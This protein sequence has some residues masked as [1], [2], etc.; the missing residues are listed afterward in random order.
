[1]RVLADTH[2]VLW[3]FT[4]S[5]R[6]TERATSLLEAETTDV[7]LS[8]VVVWEIA[9]KRAIGKLDA[10]TRYRE[11]FLGAGAEALPIEHHHAE[12]A[13]ALPPH[14]RDPFD[15]ML[16]A[17]AQLEDAIIVTADPAFAAYDVRTAW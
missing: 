4:D 12:R 6:L 8:A 17:Q 14:H 13:G 10:P 15:R 9:I 1:M 2:I 11:A 16:V 3:Y 5:D 7:L